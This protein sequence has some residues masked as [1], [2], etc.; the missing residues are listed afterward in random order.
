MSTTRHLHP[1]SH[2]GRPGRAGPGVTRPA[3]LGSWSWSDPVVRAWTAV[4]LVPVFGLVALGAAWCVYTLLGYRVGVDDAPLWVDRV[5]GLAGFVI[6]LVP[7]LLAARYGNRARMGR[8]PRG[9]APLV[10]GT[11]V[12]VWWLATGFFALAGSL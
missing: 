1:P 2:P 10:I 3:R 6:F 5:A 11:L 7:C 4:G 8:D 9:W 12:G